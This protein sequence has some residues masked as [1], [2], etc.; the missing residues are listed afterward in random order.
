MSDAPEKTYLQWNLPN[1]LTITL[2]ASF[3]VIVAGI[4][5]TGLKKL[6]G[7]NDENA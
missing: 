6:R 3:G 4:V 7:G 1:W 5:V 2:M